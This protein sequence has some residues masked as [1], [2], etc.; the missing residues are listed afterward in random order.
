[1]KFPKEYFIE[2]QFTKEALSKLK[3]SALR[4]IKIAENDKEPEVRFHF[5]YM[6][7]LKTGILAIAIKGY[8]IKSKPGH[9]KI[10]LEALANILE[11]KDVLIT[12][13]RMRKNRNF[14]V[15]SGSITIGIEEIE[16]NFTFIKEVYKRINE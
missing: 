14:D 13:D 12:G 7:L 1:M 6:A 5:S 15:Y 3:E 10:I 16:Q 11:D 4:D 2:Q 8:R 9:H